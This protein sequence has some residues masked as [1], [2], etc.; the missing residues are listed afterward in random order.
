M[1]TYPGNNLAT[2]QYENTQKFLFQNEFYGIGG[3]QQMPSLNFRSIAYQLRRERGAS[4]PFGASFELHFSGAP[5]AFA[6]DV[7][8][9]DTDVDVNYVTVNTF[10][11]VNA[12]N[13]ASIQLP[14]FWAKF[15]RAV[16]QTLT[17]PV[18]TTLM[19]TR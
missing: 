17:N 18:N 3:G 4:I 19:V 10:N 15:V 7:Q 6:I 8:T 5:G 11:A 14:A 13:S 1:P 16:I 9:A 12:N 2:L